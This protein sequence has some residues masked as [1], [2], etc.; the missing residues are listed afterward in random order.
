MSKN[1]LLSA[2]IEAAL[3]LPEES[4]PEERVAAVRSVLD[5][6]T[7][8]DLAQLEEAVLQAFAD[9]SSPDGE[10]PS[11]E[12]LVELER[13]AD[14]ADAVRTRRAEVQAA[15][16]ARAE[17]AR[18]IAERVSSA[19]QAKE[20]ADAKAKADTEPQ[21]EVPDGGEGAAPAG[22][23]MPPLV[24]VADPVAQQVPEPIA[25]TAARELANRTTS[26]APALLRAPVRVPLNQDPTQLPPGRQSSFSVIAASDS[27]G[28]SSGTELGDIKAMSNAVMAKMR[29]LPSSGGTVRQGILQIRRNTAPEFTTTN[30]NDDWLKVEAAAN[31]RRLP[32]GSLVASTG[33]GG[34]CAPSEILYDLCEGASTD[35][36]VDLP[37]VTVTRGGLRWPQTPDFA[38]IYTGSGFVP[39]STDPN[40]ISFVMDEATVK[41][42]DGTAG[43]VKPCYEVPCPDFSE[44]RLDVVGL[45]LKAGILTNHAYPELIQYFLEQAM[46]A[47]VHKMNAEII[48]RMAKLACPVDFQG[49]PAGT[50]T[51]PDPA[52]PI[53]SGLN[54]TSTALGAIELQ[55]MDLRYRYRWSENETL[56][57]VAPIFAKGIIRSDI[58]KRM[59]FDD[60]YAVSDAMMTSWF[61]LRGVGVQWVYDW[62]DALNPNIPST[63]HPDTTNC[64]N[65]T[66]PAS[67]A[68]T[69]GGQAPATAWPT[70]VHFLLYK[71]GTFVRG[72]ADVI[73]IDGLYDSAT[74]ATNRYTALFMEEG[75]CVGKRC[76]DARL[77][78]VNL[79]PN[80]AVGPLLTPPDCSK[81]V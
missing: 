58:S 8:T 47:H 81:A 22:D 39:P 66:N 46:V 18:Q 33:G 36:L 25:A 67:A 20:D 7:G 79:C 52:H 61:A 1:S 17:R 54:A 2:L 12:Q 69:F 30:S 10:T 21:A 51:P 41:G 80:G 9:S 11:D 44:C 78:R 74:L 77:I 19:A 5:A 16:D 43:H 32:G 38:S 68:A 76:F 35:G 60:P 48:N 75:L 3:S 73:T 59:G 53:Q 4:T 23:G 27:P 31:E 50:G 13:L 37:S 40:G 72:S 42:L 45:C 14:V 70:Q 28:V 62:L 49:W 65:F 71:A 34:W 64:K 63:S 29:T 55:V 26:A 24:P 56:E 57:L 15:A 6:E